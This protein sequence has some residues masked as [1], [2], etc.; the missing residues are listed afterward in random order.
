MKK[1][2][3]NTATRSVNLFGTL[4]RRLLSN[5]GAGEGVASEPRQQQSGVG[6]SDGNGGAGGGNGGSHERRRSSGAAASDVADASGTRQNYYG[7]PQSQA[8][9]LVWNIITFKNQILFI[10]FF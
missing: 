2:R 5:A 3:A 7:Q 4:K 6:G 1:G 9:V 10:Y 8:N